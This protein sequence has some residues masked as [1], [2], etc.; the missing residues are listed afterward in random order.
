MLHFERR[1]W[2]LVVCVVVGD[3]GGG[4]PRAAL[5]CDLCGHLASGL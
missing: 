4:R 1:V 2:K 5:T 3:F